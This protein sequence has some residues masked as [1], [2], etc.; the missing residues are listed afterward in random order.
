[1]VTWINNN[2]NLV[3]FSNLKVER[4]IILIIIEGIM[5]IKEREN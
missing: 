4:C 2:V 5:K 3:C 1:M